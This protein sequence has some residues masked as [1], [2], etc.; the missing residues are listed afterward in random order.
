LEKSK[1]RFVVGY[2]V[3]TYL[4]GLVNPYKK[5]D[6]QQLRFKE[7]LLLFVAKTY[8]PISIVES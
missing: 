2:G 4:F 8:M 6:P 7:D 1:K 5:D 3:I